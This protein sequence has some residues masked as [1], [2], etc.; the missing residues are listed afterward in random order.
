LPGAA[1]ARACGDAFKF[2]N[3]FRLRGPLRLKKCTY[4]RPFKLAMTHNFLNFPRGFT[5]TV[6]VTGRTDRLRHVESRSK[7][8]DIAAPGTGGIMIKP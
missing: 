3:S 2:A 8:F 7:Y 1:G 5:V 6:T 4:R